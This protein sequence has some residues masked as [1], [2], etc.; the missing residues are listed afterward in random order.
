MAWHGGDVEIGEPAEARSWSR[1]S[2]KYN[3]RVLARR[4]EACG[5]YDRSGKKL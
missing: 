4:E 3:E 1:S 5:K 2:K